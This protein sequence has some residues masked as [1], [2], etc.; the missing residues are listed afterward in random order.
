MHAHIRDPKREFPMLIANG[1]LGIRD[2]GGVPEKI[3]HWSEQVASGAVLGPRI[4]A[5]GPIVEGP[6]PSNPPISV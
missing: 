1:V 2:M 6:E 3:F 5:C 4:V